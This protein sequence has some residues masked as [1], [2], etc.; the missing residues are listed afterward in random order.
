MDELIK[1]KQLEFCRSKTI[2]KQTIHS[3]VQQG[4]LNPQHPGANSPLEISEEALVV[5]CIQMSMIRQSLTSKEGIHLRNS[6]ISVDKIVT[7][8]RDKFAVDRSDWRT[9]KN[10]KQIFDIIYDEIVAVKINDIY[11]FWQ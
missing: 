5:I 11:L 9:L 1:T 6:L 10:T 7:K 3:H 2:P 8:K 4:T